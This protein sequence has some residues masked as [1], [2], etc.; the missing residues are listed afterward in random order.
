MKIVFSTKNV[1]RGTFL[2]TCRYAFDYGFKGFEIYDAVKERN[3][4]H[5]SILRRDRMADAKRKLVNRNLAVSALRMPEAVDGENTT[6][7]M[8]VKYIEMAATAGV[9]NVIVRVDKAVSFDVLDALIESEWHECRLCAL[10]ILVNK[11]RKMPDEV[12]EFYLSHTAW[13]NNWDLVDLSA[14]YVLG[15]WL[16]DKTDRSILY[17]LAQSDNM[18]EQRIAVVS[19]LMLIRKGQFNDTV[20]LAEYF[21]DTKHD[22]MRKAVGWMLREV[23]KRDHALLVGFLETHR[24]RIPRT[25]LRYAIERFTPEQRAYFMKNKH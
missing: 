24:C 15:A 3:F 5:D 4:H 6:A 12:V 25:T 8:V 7:D 21:F 18:W 1:S 17:S 23:G 9:S 16:A 22:L 11:F 19:T 2:D 14:P 10:V 13:I 20:A